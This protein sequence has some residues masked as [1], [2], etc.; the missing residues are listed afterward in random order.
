M[1]DITLVNTVFPS[2]VKVPPQGTLYLTAALEHAGFSVDIRDYQLCGYDDPWEPAAL[3]RF[4]DRCAPVVGFSAM[5]YALPLIIAA[6][7]IIKR[8]RP[9]IVIVVGGIGPS[10]AGAALLEFCAEIDVIVVGEG[11]RTIVD[12]MRAL[13]E[14]RNPAAVAGLIC[15][16][17]GRIVTTQPRPR[18]ASMTELARPAY[19][20]IDMSQY[21]LVD[22][23]FGRGCPFKCTFCDIA[24]YWGRLNTHRPIDHYVDELEWLVRRHGASDVFIVDDTFVL[25]R[26]SILQFCAEITRRNLRFEWG[27]YARVDLMDEELIERMAQAGCR[28]IFYGVES[29]SDGVLGDIVKETGVETITDIV[30]RSL[31]HV[32]FV[33][34]SFVWGFPNESLEDFKQTVSLL[35]YLTAVGASPQL[36]LVLPYSYSTL[37]QQYRD[38][39]HFDPR[40]ASQLTF[41]ENSDKTWLHDMIAADRHLFSAFYLLPTPAF[42]A[43]WS[44]LEEVGLSP[45]ELQRAY[46]HP[47][48][49][50][51][52]DAPARQMARHAS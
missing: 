47:V 21:R 43:K 32:P 45:H 31:R 2:E 8:R 51:K 15:R 9:D 46:D 11:E 36:N 13:R 16:D 4:V 30:T 19:H 38:A 12:L 28:K 26:K 48:L 17:K 34:A 20:R 5:S 6:S 23:Q 27:C 14:R 42:E 7:R 33:T 35:L 24:P 44:Y 40:Y 41:Y 1:S 50:S 29:G 18:I 22:S 39:I 49:P 10:G 3:A 37:Y 25:S 52:D